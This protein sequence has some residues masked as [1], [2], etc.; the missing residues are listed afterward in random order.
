MLVPALFANGT[1]KPKEKESCI[2]FAM[3]FLLLQQVS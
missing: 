1:F 3:F 2:Q